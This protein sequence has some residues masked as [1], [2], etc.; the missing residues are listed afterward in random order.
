MRN[1]VEPILVALIT[2]PLSTTRVELATTLTCTR[3]TYG[4]GFD[5]NVVVEF[6]TVTLPIRAIL[7]Y[8]LLDPVL[9]V[10]SDET[11]EE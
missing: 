8:P 10:K 1:A 7:S 9:F 2:V 4:N 3:K 11:P 5:F 6:A